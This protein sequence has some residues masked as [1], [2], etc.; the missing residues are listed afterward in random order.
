[1]KHF[2]CVTLSHAYIFSSFLTKSLSLS[3]AYLRV[4]YATLIALAAFL[5]ESNAVGSMSSEEITNVLL[6]YIGLKPNLAFNSFNL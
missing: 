2:K 3:F 5:K 1:M 4:P 6:L